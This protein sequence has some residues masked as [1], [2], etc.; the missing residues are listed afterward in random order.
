MKDCKD[1]SNNT[2]GCECEKYSKQLEQ[3]KRVL[4]AEGQAIL[5]AAERIC[6]DV[7]FAKAA[8]LIHDC[9]GTVVLT[10][11]GKAG[12]I[13]QK[14][15][16]TLA[17]TGTLSIFLHPVEALHGD[18]GRLQRADVVIALSNSG[19]SEEIVRLLDHIKRR[20]SKL[21][22]I[23]AANESPLGNHA[24]VAISYGNFDEACPLGLAPSVSTTVMLAVGDAL[25]ITVMEMRN[26]KPEEY[27]TYHPGGALGRQFLKVEEVMTSRKGEHLSLARDNL[28]VGEALGAAEKG[29]RRTG[30]MLLVDENGNLTGILT[31]ADL[32]RAFVEN[33]D[34][35][36][37][38]VPISDLMTKAPKSIKLGDL[39]SEAEAIF[40]QYR[41]D[42]LPVVDDSGKPVGVLDVQDLLGV[43][44]LKD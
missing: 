42:E 17:S 30:A 9:K 16:A 43:K 40:N 2:C 21:I 19:S 33:S 41:I 35:N 25:A 31:D 6:Q 3:G 10:G 15:S 7:A 11:V 1:N 27:A 12:I 44:T 20:G 24:D 8:E 22:A 23:T 28:T 18:L 39:A 36:I 5:S 29:G 37:Q 4:L 26:F 32:R 13:A 34:G 38:S 14:I